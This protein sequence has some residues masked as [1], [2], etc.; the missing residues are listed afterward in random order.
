MFVNLLRDLKK[1]STFLVRFLENITDITSILVGATLVMVLF[2][3]TMTMMHQG[4]S[5]MPTLASEPQTFYGYGKHI[6]YLNYDIEEPTYT[7]ITS[8]NDLD[9]KQIP[10]FR[11]DNSYNVKDKDIKLFKNQKVKCTKYTKK[12]HLGHEDISIYY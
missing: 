2:A 11:I 3:G 4:H 1:D 9:G 6:E 7:I 12:T 8:K 5:D 10:W